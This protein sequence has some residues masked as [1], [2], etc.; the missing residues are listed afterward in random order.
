MACYMPFNS[1]NLDVNILVLKP[2][3]VLVDELVDAL[4]HFSIWTETFGCVH[5]SI[6]QSIHGNMIVW[7]GAWMKRSD[8]DKR[9]LNSAIMSM[10]TNISSM[11]V[12]MDYS[13]FE[14]YAGE[15][16]TGSASAR[17][18]TGDTVSF[19]II[20]HTADE[21]ISQLDLSYTILATFKS[22]FLSMDGVT[23]GVCLKKYHNSK[24]A[25]AD[26]FILNFFVWKS[27]Q[28]CYSYIL[29]SDIKDVIVPYL[30]GLSL[31]FKYDIFRVIYVS[32][33]NLM[34]FQYSP[35]PPHQMLQTKKRQERSR[36]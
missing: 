17:F 20:A 8:N 7:Y 35:S 13:F 4:K 2:K 36:P 12:L 28:S 5:S 23:S 32:G 9:S 19:S 31:D 11:A 30:K 18:S 25:V 10:L 24:N 33:D 1:R 29:K 34:D 22:S 27:L 26:E 14:T 3:I 15:S 6:L 16:K 21:N